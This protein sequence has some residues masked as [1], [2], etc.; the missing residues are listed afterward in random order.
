MGV[1]SGRVLS[2]IGWPIFAARCDG[3]GIGGQDVVEG[4]L[5]VIIWH[6]DGDGRELWVEI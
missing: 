6:G 5:G 4:S 2:R 1:R 3:P